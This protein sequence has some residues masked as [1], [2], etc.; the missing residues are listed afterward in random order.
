[1]PQTISPQAL[2]QLRDGHAPFA[3]ID[4][5]E[6]GE[7]N[8]AHIPDSS[9]I[10]R[11]QL[12]WLMATAV[13]VHHIPVVVYDD[14]GQRATLAAATMIKNKPATTAEVVAVP[15]SWAPPRT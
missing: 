7:H 4:V 5:R 8:S 1:M 15:T 3:L 11:R 14:N 9:L 10:P 2:Q 12:E 6:A 13:P